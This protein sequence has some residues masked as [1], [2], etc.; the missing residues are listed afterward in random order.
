[1]T[2][3]S[4]WWARSRRAVGRRAGRVRWR[5]FLPTPPGAGSDPAAF[6]AVM[7]HPLHGRSGSTVLM[8]LLGTSPAVYFEHEYP[9][10]Y[11]GLSQV[12]GDARASCPPELEAV[13]QRWERFAVATAARSPGARVYAQ[14]GWGRT[15]DVLLAAG[16]PLRIVNLVRDPRDTAAS[17]LAF[18]DKRG[19]YG[20]GR[21]PG[22]SRA[23]FLAWLG[24]E[25][26]T[27]LRV[28]DDLTT[29]A[30]CLLVRYEDLVGDLAAT[31]RTVG[32]FVGVTLDADLCQ[33]RTRR[34]R[35]HRTTASPASSIGRWRS[36]LPADEVALLTR[37]LG[38]SLVRLGY[39]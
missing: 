35:D 36:D 8:E 29:R 33:R 30:D 17:V 24:E 6:A 15:V 11:D 4:D 3:R 25:M 12:V 37:S 27:T 31:A 38:D 13:R 23:E 26:A 22:Q 5:R 9:Y 39:A 28:M 1:M 32:D 34:Y 2:G 19:T 20:F 18:D 21:Q 7:V 14:K 10:E 16:L